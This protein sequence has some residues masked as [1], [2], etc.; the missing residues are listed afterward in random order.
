[1][2]KKLSGSSSA[3][4]NG[5]LQEVHWGRAKPLTHSRQNEWRHGRSLG[6]FG[7]EGVYLE[8]H[9]GH[10]SSVI[11]GLLSIPSRMVS[12]SMLLMG[13]AEADYK[14]SVTKAREYKM[15]CQRTFVAA[16]CVNAP[17]RNNNGACTG[18]KWTICIIRRRPLHIRT[19]DFLGRRSRLRLIFKFPALRH[20]F[21]SMYP[22][23]GLIG[24]RPHVLLRIRRLTGRRRGV[25]NL[26]RRPGCG[27]NVHAESAKW[28]CCPEDE[29]LI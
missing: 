3:D 23:P 26:L 12:W 13:L 19:V 21:F 2:A 20:R 28:V 18:S 1:M 10:V 4:E 29:A 8:E 27:T 5:F 17:N 7:A 15:I 16:R 11:G 9:R 25:K 14:R 22:R 6:F 24:I